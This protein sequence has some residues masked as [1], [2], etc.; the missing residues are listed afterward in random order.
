MKSLLIIVLF[1]TMTSS[2]STTPNSPDIS[3]D[4]EEITGKWH[5]TETLADPGDGSGTWKTVENGRIL[6]FEN[7][8]IVTSS[9]T[10]CYNEEIYEASYD[11]A[12]KMINSDCADRTIA[13]R[14]EI[15]EGDLFIYPHNPRCIE[16]CG[17]KYEKVED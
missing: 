3:L 10:Y 2:C 13:L 7:D 14:Y 5:L 15:K 6:E 17:S 9:T 1:A 12:E 4:K 11:T 8:G 16:A